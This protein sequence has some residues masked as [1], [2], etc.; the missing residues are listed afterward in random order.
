MN[1]EAVAT[2]AVAAPPNFGHLRRLT[3]DMGLFEHAEFDEPR[4]EHGYTTDD[5]ARALVVVSRARALGSDADHEPYLG[6]VLGGAVAGGWHNRMSPSGQWVDRRGSDDC[7]GRVIWGLGE[8]IAS[9]SGNEETWDLYQAAVHTID[10]T[11]PLSLA[12][13]ILGVCVV[14]DRTGNEFLE[15]FLQGVSEKFPRPATGRRRWPM[16]RLTYDNARVPQA[17]IEWGRVTG[18]DS[19]T[20]SGLELLAWLIREET[21][22]NGFSFTPVGGRGPDDPKP[23][24]DQQPIE[25]WA[26]ADACVSAMRVDDHSTWRDG[27]M[28]AAAWFEGLN[29]AGLELYDPDTG[30]GYDGLHRGGVNQNRGA[31][32]TL[33]ALGA[34]LA[35]LQ[36]HGMP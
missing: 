19:M 5:N 27:V 13:A 34:M 9:G 10:T 4:I 16:E 21:G 25:A 23:G 30:A 22:E 17:L 28:R 1:A 3:D 12:Y 18:D 31:E 33:S 29:D 26:M 36:V 8:L 35:R 24:F 6:F 14:L 15:G 7:H 2:V 32:S 20:E 11:H